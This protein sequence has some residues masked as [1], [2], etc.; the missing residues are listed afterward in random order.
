MNSKRSNLANGPDPSI[1]AEDANT[2]QSEMRGIEEPLRIP[3]KPRDILHICN[4]ITDGFDAL[5][6]R[7]KKRGIDRLQ[8]GFNE[9]DKL[10]CGLHEEDF[11]VIAG[12]D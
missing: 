11:V 6:Q 5:Q 12:P 9:F 8:T 4:V 10:T 2:G 7:S 3:S 1:T